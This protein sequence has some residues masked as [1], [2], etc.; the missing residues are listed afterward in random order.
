MQE[1]ASDLT[2]VEPSTTR[3]PAAEDRSKHV[4]RLENEGED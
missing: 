4:A 2:F 1:A 3:G